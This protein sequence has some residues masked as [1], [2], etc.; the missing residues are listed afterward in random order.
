MK[1]L[2]L[3]AWALLPRKSMKI[4]EMRYSPH[5]PQAYGWGKGGITQGDP[6]A[7]NLAWLS[8]DLT[9]QPMP[10]PNFSTLIRRTLE[11]VLASGRIDLTDSYP[12]SEKV[13]G[14][15]QMP[16]AQAV[17]KILTMEHLIDTPMFA[18]Y[19]SNWTDTLLERSR[20]Y[21]EP[22]DPVLD[23]TVPDLTQALA[24]IDHCK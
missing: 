20:L 23:R 10:A 19:G 3:P 18:A 15:L 9:K 8:H 2:M 16:P 14:F 1:R 5:P 24:I 22:L 13:R 4:A 11:F 12:A 21:R 17:Q 6:E 7:W